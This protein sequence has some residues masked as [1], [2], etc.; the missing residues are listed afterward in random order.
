MGW[1]SGR[2]VASLPCDR[3]NQMGL[4]CVIVIVLWKR[5]VER[6]PLVLLALGVVAL[7]S[8]SSSGGSG[9]VTGIFETSGGPPGYQPHRLPGNVVFRD[10]KGDHVSVRVGE[11][12]DVVVHLPAGTYTAVGHSPMI[13]SGSGEMACDA[14]HPVVVWAGHTQRVT[15]ACQLM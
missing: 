14:L 3:T 9:T 2:A 11:S 15:V 10:E 12:G 1:R 4:M 13:H 8:C 5:R 6:W 7:S